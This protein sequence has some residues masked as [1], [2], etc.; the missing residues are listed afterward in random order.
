MAETSLTKTIGRSYRATVGDRLIGWLRCHWLGVFVSILIVFT[1]LPFLAPVLM[2]V[3]L[4]GPGKAIYL[5][6][7][8]LCHQLPQRSYFL[9]GPKLSYSL[10]EIQVAWQNTS[11][12]VILRQFI[13]SPESGWKVAW[14]DRMVSMYTSLPVFALLWRSLLRRLPRLP[15]WG[16]IL[17]LLPMALDG[18]THFISDLWGIGQGFRYTNVWLA[19]LTGRT[20]PASFY[21]GDA[22]G[23]FNSWMRLVTGIL[24]GLGIIWFVMPFVEAAFQVK[25][26]SQTA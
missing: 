23:S 9:F 14:S 13:G 16:L 11:N 15:W 5:I 1:G 17:F 20:F 22:L 19:E 2:E 6:Y 12:P 18:T 3:G 21:V 4:T 8:F 26:N 25:S 24:F 7:S 10:A